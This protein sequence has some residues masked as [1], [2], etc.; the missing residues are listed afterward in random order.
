[1][2]KNEW[3]DET[4]YRRGERGKIEPRTWELRTGTDLRVQVHRI[5]FAD[6]WFASCPELHLTNRP[7]KST[8]VEDAK[9]EAL[10][11][12]RGEL[13]AMTTHLD[14]AIAM[15]RAARQ[16]AMYPE[17]TCISPNGRTDGHGMYLQ[18][19]DAGELVCM[20]CK[21]APHAK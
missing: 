19:N 20:F 8:E 13:Y 11:L 14:H 15:D 16:R 9:P 10:G 3:V 6:G 4:S 12:V 7:L 17:G 18:G 5:L 2:K 21:K 1:M